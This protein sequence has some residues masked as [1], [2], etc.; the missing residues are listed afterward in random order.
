MKKIKSLILICVLAICSTF[1][2]VACDSST[3]TNSETIKITDMLGREVAVPTEINRVA[4]IGAGSLR[5]YSYIGDMDKLCGVED[6][7]KDGT[8]VGGNISIRP[9]KM[10]NAKKLNTL[11]SCG[12]GGPSGKVEAEKILTCKP[13]IIFSLYTSDKSAMDELQNSTKIPVV[14]LSYG[15]TEAFDKNVKDSLKLMGKILNKEDRANE[16]VDYINNIILELS[17]I[18][19]GVKEKDKPSIYL[20]CQSNYGTH[21]IESSTADY[22]IFKASNIKNVL[23]INNLSGYQKNIDLEALLTMNPD[24]IILDAGGLTILKHQYAENTKA[25]IFNKMKAF[26]NGEVYLQMPYNAYYT[27]LEI[28]YIDAYFD[29]WVSYPQNMTD[30]NIETKAREIFVKFLG[31]DCYDEVAKEMFGGYQKLDLSKTFENYEA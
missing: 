27:N 22:S 3:N 20:G 14:T 8:G 30:F 25:A 7:D 29:A 6:I 17:D 12:V 31:K 16:L 23:D 11:P 28:A 21:G 26:K 19:L 1:S 2:L 5:L 18:S 24:K 13:D 4:C 15:K 10:V 9:Y